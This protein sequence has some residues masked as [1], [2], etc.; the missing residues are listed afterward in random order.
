MAVEGVGIQAGLARQ[1]PQA[2]GTQTAALGTEAQRRLHE[3]ALAR[4]VGASLLRLLFV[5]A[6]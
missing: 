1:F 4:R 2:Q 5:G 3:Q 6:G